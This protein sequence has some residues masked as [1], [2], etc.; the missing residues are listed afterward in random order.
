MEI[1]QSAEKRMPQ[2]LDED[3]SDEER[4][5]RKDA[6]RGV[7]SISWQSLDQVPST[8]GQKV[9]IASSD[10]AKA[11]LRILF[12]DALI[13][14]ASAEVTTEEEKDPKTILKIF[15]GGDLLILFP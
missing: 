1:D 4:E 15:Q 3:E 12:D 9:V 6:E 10:V 2:G 7:F 14:V 8:E 5:L 13:E 11:T